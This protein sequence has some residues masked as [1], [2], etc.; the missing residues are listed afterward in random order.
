MITAH[1]MNNPEFRAGDN[2]VLAEG[3][4]PGTP[5]VFLKLS[6]D[7]QLGGHLGAQWRGP[8]SPGEMAAT[9]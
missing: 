4:Y 6:D 9:L 5:G 7:S 3:T 2:V 1:P 8:I